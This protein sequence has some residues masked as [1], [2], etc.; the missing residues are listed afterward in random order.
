[1]QRNKNKS[2]NTSKQYCLNMKTAL[3]EYQSWKQWDDADA[4]AMAVRKYTT[5]AV[6]S[7]GGGGDG[8]AAFCACVTRHART[9]QT[10][11]LSSLSSW[12]RGVW[13]FWRLRMTALGPPSSNRLDSWSRRSMFSSCLWIVVVIDVLKNLWLWCFVQLKVWHTLILL[14]WR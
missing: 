2:I 14:K 9:V 7:G 10:S 12:W 13:L 3:T 11:L 6:V 1:M 4:V 5:A 8:C